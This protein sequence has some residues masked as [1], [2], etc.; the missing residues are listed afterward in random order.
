M[1]NNGKR[2]YEMELEAQWSKRY[3][4]SA[5]YITRH[6]ESC[7]IF[8]IPEKFIA[9]FERLNLK[10]RASTEERT[11]L[12]QFYLKFVEAQKFKNVEEVDHLVQFIIDKWNWT[13]RQCQSALSIGDSRYQRLKRQLLPRIAEPSESLIPELKLFIDSFDQIVANTIDGTNKNAP[14]S[15]AC[16][17]HCHLQLFIAF[18]LRCVDNPN[19]PFLQTDLGDVVDFSP[20][21]KE[22]K[23]KKDAFLD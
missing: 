13:S 23:T 18:S 6:E 11:T 14:T 20:R 12:V 5:K 7:H 16:R 22:W 1:E 10:R 8:G 4:R 15:V 19:E 3:R 2:R 9:T 21:V 17:Q